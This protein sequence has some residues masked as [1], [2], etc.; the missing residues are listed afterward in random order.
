LV[1]AACSAYPFPAVPLP[2]RPGVSDP[3]GG[4]KG[5]AGFSGAGAI[6]FFG[7]GVSG[8]TA[9]APPLEWGA[10]GFAAGGRQAEKHRAQNKT[11]AVKIGRIFFTTV[12]FAFSRKFIC[13][14]ILEQA[15]A[16]AVMSS[17]AETY[18]TI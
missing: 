2:K 4:F 14:G 18:P 13:M 1:N 17:E 10:G 5:A 11:A 6:G 9:S 15:T 7:A 12:V 3:A 8:K 16:I